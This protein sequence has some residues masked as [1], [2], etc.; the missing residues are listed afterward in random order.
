MRQPFRSTASNIHLF[1]CDADGL[2]AS[3][4]LSLFFT[5]MGIENSVIIPTRDQGYGL[6]CDLVLKAFENNWYDLLIT[7]D[8][9][10]SNKEEIAQLKKRLAMAWILLLQTT[11]RFQTNCQTVFV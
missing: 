10:I 11:T 1:D 2:S 5:N 4:L 9:G 7:V 8:C 3:A 6:H